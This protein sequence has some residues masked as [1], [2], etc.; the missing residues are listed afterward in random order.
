MNN[1]EKIMS[2]LE[3]MQSGMENMQS[4]MKTMKDDMKTM[5]DDISNIKTRLT[6]VE[7][8][9]ENKINK[10]IQILK[11]GH[12]ALVEKLWRL[13]E[14]IE[15][16]QESVSILKFVQREMAKKINQ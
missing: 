12:Q 14:E 6:G 13:P 9:I 10:N 4:D 1:E 5:K 8:T 3:T 15:D 16:I 7:L 11:D 2:I